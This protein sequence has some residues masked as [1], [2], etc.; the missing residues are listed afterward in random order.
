[1]CYG[2]NITGLGR[3]L[4][5]LTP[6]FVPLKRHHPEKI[7]RYTQYRVMGTGSHLLIQNIVNVLHLFL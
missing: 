6:S 5:G 7:K 2:P 1:M 4:G 3:F